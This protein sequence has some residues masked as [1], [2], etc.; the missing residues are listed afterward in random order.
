MLSVQQLPYTDTNPLATDVGGYGCANPN[1]N[2]TPYMQ[3]LMVRW[4]QF[5]CFCP[6]FRTHGCRNGPSEP[7]VSPCVNV[8]RSCGENEV[9]S[10]GNATQKI[11]SKYIRLRAEMKPYVQ[12]LVANVTKSGVPTMRPLAFAF[13]SDTGSHG[14][15][16]QYMFGD[17]LLVAPVTVQGAV[18]R[19]VYFPAGAKWTNFFNSQ[20]VVEGGQRLVV[21]APLDTIPVYRRS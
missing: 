20:D 5:G 8:H 1:P 18:N 11:L 2:D 21:D 19:S 15:N 3:E 17:D 12:D 13:P 9:W 16:D 10:Y 6:V 14:I 4:Y 7:D